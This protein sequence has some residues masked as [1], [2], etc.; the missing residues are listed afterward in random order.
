VAAAAVLSARYSTLVLSLIYGLIGI[1]LLPRFIWVAAVI[2]ITSLAAFFLQPAFLPVVIALFG[3]GS[4]FL[5]GLWMQ[6][7]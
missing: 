2:A 5:G 4:L 3:G 1:F 7:L 6:R